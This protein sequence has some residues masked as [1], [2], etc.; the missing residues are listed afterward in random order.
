MTGSGMGSIA[1]MWG[2]GV[3]RAPM[4]HTGHQSTYY[5]FVLSDTWWSVLRCSLPLPVD[6]FL[7][8]ASVGW[9]LW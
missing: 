1:D 8:F 6:P 4:L 2:D 9:D 3:V 5:G 7:F